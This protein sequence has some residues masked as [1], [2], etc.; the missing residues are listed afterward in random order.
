[1]INNK[2]DLVV[3]FDTT[4]SM[5]PV[6]RQVRQEVEK[7]V[8]QMFSEFTDLRLGIIAHGDYCDAGDPYT[9]INMELTRDEERLCK[10]VK[11]VKQT[12]GGDA[13]ECYELVLNSAH[14]NMMWRP[15]ADK[16]MIMIGDAN[17]HGV[18]YKQN[19]R[20]LDWETEA[21]VL[22]KLGIRVFSVHALSYYRSSS[23]K[24]Y[25]TVA[26][27][28][29]GIYL[30]LDQFNEIVDLIKATLY[31]QAGEEKLNEYITVIKDNGR[32]TNSLNRNFRRLKGEVVEDETH[33]YT[34][35]KISE[36]KVR[37]AGAIKEMGE[38]V[39]VLPGRFQVMTVPNDVAI[40]AFV[41]ENGIKF[42][43]GRG[44]YELT[45]AVKVQQYKEII[46]QDRETGEMFNGTQVREKLGLKPQTESGGVTESLHK[47][48][49]KEFR[50]FIQSTSVNRKLIGGTTFLYE[51]DDIEDVSTPVETV[52]K[53]EAVRLEGLTKTIEE[54]VAEKETEDKSVEEKKDST[55][56]VE[57]TVK[58]LEKVEDIKAVKAKKPR[59]KYTK[60]EMK[61]VEAVVEEKVAE[62]IEE[63]K[64]AEVKEDTS[65]KE[66][67][68]AIAGEVVFTEIN[69][70]C[71]ELPVVDEDKKEEDMGKIKKAEEKARK[72]EEKAAKALA[73]EERAI[74][75]LNAKKEKEAKAKEVNTEK[76]TA[77]MEKA[78]DAI[79][80]I[81]KSIK[82]KKN[83]V[84][85]KNN[86]EKLMKECEKM[87]EFVDK[88]EE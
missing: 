54:R 41:E 52:V 1:M 17:P 59:K 56:V 15:D 81:N 6:L 76:L 66:V 5:Y 42:K 45:K 19:E 43:T 23:K 31:Q 62:V 77:S 51:V 28:T 13:D 88:Y 32:M 70:D 33:R 29:D 10:F 24:F 72:A 60:P 75:K 78:N 50:V 14:E 86:I 73:K 85:F 27:T 26:K 49:L 34:A 64:E 35:R 53:P 74:A 83:R 36:R 37:E 71:I 69:T 30:T 68:E 79:E 9:I 40:K 80:R 84:Y 61:V 21:K 58:E 39:P 11:E 4:G 48:A 46:I 20:R 65:A 47:D 12:W 55:A 22:G 3:S 82:N 8:K 2:I 16:I 63:I 18:Y 7:F 87:L 57:D 44:F 25:E 38:L 67:E